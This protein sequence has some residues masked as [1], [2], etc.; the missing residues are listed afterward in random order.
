[1]ETTPSEL[2]RYEEL[3]MQAIDFA[4][5][6]DTDT[7]RR[8]IAVG[9]PVNLSDA[10][11]QTLLMIA[12]YNGNLETTRMLLEAGAEVDRRNDRG[13]TPLGGVAFKGNLEAVK[14]LLDY[15]ADANADNGN[16]MTPLSYAK[17]FGRHEVAAYL[18]SQ[19]AKCTLRDRL[20]GIPG[21][22]FGHL[23]PGQDKMAS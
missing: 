18:Q 8:M 13:Q 5:T 22:I 11:G 14:L 2:E 23:V 9:M 7:L 16:G 15:G 12:S 6:G 17:M 20:L 3:Q 19:G 10:K 4:R 1:M 21:S